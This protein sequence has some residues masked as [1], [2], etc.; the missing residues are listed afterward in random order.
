[1]FGAVPL[2]GVGLNGGDGAD[3]PPA[4]VPKVAFGSADFREAFGDPVRAA[5]C[6]GAKNTHRDFLF[7]CG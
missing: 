1:M 6:K 7:C 3:Y 4:S 2:V 5:P